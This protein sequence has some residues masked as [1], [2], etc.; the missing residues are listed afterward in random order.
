MAGYL[1]VAVEALEQRTDL[2]DGQSDRERAAKGAIRA[3][4]SI[5]RR[6]ETASRLERS[7]S[8]PRVVTAWRMPEG[9][10]EFGPVELA[11]S[12]PVELVEDH[13]RRK[14]KDMEGNG[15]KWKEME[16]NGREGGGRRWSLSSSSKITLK[17]RT[18]MPRLTSRS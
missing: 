3:S 18:L 2:T 16:G 6:L 1:S 17:S 8:V 15:R 11:R 12:I 9:L 10:L 5:N 7:A 14:W 13:L 4:A